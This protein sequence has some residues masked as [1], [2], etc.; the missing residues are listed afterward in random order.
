VQGWFTG[1]DWSGLAAKTLESPHA[2]IASA[3]MTKLGSA[4]LADVY[5]GDDDWAK[6]FSSFAAGKA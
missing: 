3:T 4:T 1:F 2:S 5:S 6:E